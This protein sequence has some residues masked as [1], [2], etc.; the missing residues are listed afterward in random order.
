MCKR[1]AHNVFSWEYT[2]YI[3][4]GFFFF[5]FNLFVS[6]RCA[7]TTTSINNREH[8]QKKVRSKK[9]GGLRGSP[10]VGE[11]HK[12]HYWHPKALK[13]SRQPPW[14]VLFYT[15]MILFLWGEG[16]TFIS[17]LY[18]L[19]PLS[20]RLQARGLCWGLIPTSHLKSRVRHWGLTL[21]E[22]KDCFEG[23][24]VPQKKRRERKKKIHKNIW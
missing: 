4:G 11:T 15:I 13:P 12:P 9:K 19:R 3:G 23:G 14:M 20:F 7:T 24:G 2:E 6:L 8:N 22:R 17:T 18:S 16:I 21:L 1:K 10:G 5:F